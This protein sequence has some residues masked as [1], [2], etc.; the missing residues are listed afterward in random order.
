[1]LVGLLVEIGLLLLL[2]F[3]P[4]LML[5]HDVGCL[6]RP[7]EPRLHLSA[8]LV[9]IGLLMQLGLLVQIGLRYQKSSY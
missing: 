4:R 8:T 9:P 6:L 5:L 2:G 3:L 7:G 1:M